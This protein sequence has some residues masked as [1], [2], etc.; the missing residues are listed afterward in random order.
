MTPP[1]F[2][3]YLLLLFARAAEAEWIAG[4]LAEEFAARCVSDGSKPARKWYVS[5]VVRSL[6]HLGAMGWRGGELASLTAASL[7]TIL[8]PLLLLDTVWSFVYSQVPLKSG[9]DLLPEFALI[10]ALVVLICGRACKPS[11]DGA[12]G[13]RTLVPAMAVVSALLLSSTRVPL[14][15]ALV[16]LA[17]GPLSMCRFSN[18]KIRRIL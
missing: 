4:D 15:C 13:W 10:N 3:E 2:S 18:Y 17:A 9:P 12:R 8:M 6:P 5:Q 16:L 11:G 14:I 1:F 7:G